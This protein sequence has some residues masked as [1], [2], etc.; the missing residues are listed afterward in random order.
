MKTMQDATGNLSR[1]Q[2]LIDAS[3]FDAVVAVSP[4][5]VLYA[6]DAFISTQIDI[7]DRL[8]L[9]AAP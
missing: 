9:L 2:A 7:R 5:N 6:S 8:A 1:L 4:E 3:E